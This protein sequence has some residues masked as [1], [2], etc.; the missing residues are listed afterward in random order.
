MMT[1]ATKSSTPSLELPPMTAGAQIRTLILSVFL[2]CLVSLVGSFII[3]FLLIIVFRTTYGSVIHNNPEGAVGVGAWAALIAAII[4]AVA[5]IPLSL[6]FFIRLCKRH[7]S[8]V[9]SN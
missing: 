9:K 3:A 4:A 5:V 1:D 7:R 6:L 2:A 8:V